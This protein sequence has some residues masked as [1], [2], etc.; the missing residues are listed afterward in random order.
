MPKREIRKRKPKDVTDLDGWQEYCSDVHD[1]AR[2]YMELQG[3]DRT[4]A[5]YYEPQNI[6][7]RN[8]YFYAN[9]WIR[10]KTYIEMLNFAIQNSVLKNKRDDARA[11]NMGILLLYNEKYLD[12]S[13]RLKYAKMLEYAY[14]HE[15]DH[16]WLLGF[17]GQCG[18][19]DIIPEK[20]KSGYIEPWRKKYLKSKKNNKHR[21]RFEKFNLSR[22]DI[23]K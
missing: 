11:H 5:S 20:L 21:K 9:E 12:T 4:A 16:R 6:R 19:I 1:R 8:A 7:L 17:I 18:G 14:L 13:Q 22:E 3:R 2:F 23:K 15:V 10:H